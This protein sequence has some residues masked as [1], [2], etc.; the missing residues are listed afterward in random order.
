MYID[1]HIH[2]HTHTYPHRCIL[3]TGRDLDKSECS[4]VLGVLKPSQGVLPGYIRDI[5]NITMLPF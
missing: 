5:E 2:T 4:V 3:K 1:R